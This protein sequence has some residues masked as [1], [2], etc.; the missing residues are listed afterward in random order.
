[1]LSGLPGG[2]VFAYDDE[3]MSNFRLNFDERTV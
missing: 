3:G 2:F 1:M